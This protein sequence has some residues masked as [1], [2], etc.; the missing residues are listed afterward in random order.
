MRVTAWWRVRRARLFQLWGVGVV[1]SLAVTTA[2]ALGYFS[3][4]QSRALDFMQRLQ[5]QR[6]ASHIVV[7]A[8]DDDAFAALGS[9]TPIPREYVA[10]IVRGLQRSGAA[11]VGFDF[12]FSSPTT[13]AADGALADAI[14]GFNERGLSRVVLADTAA[15]GEGPLGDRRLL[16]SLVRGTPR[17]PVDADGII[18]RAML[19]VPRGPG[20]V[21]EPALS[22]AVAARLA[23]LDQSALA[24]AL[25]T[26]QLSLPR[27]DASG[28]SLTTAQPVRL[29]EGETLPIA[30]VGPAQ[31][32]LTI[33]SDAVAA[34]ADPSAEIADDNPLRGRVVLVGGT[35]K[36]ARDSFPT[37]VG[38]VP[39]VE[40]HAALV[41]M[42]LTRTFIRPTGWLTSLALQA[43]VVVLAG[44]VLTLARPLI[45][46]IV[47]LGTALLVGLPASYLA[48]R[49]AGYWVDFL[50]PVLATC[51]LGIGAD[52]LARRRVR[53][54]FGRYVSREVA[55][56]ILA[57]EPSLDGERRE[58]SILISDLRGFT[59]LSE[60]M[61]PVRI[62]RHLNEYFEAMTAAIFAHRGMVND[63][64]GDS[65]IAVFGAPLSDPDHARHATLS[66]IAMERALS[67]LNQRWQAAGLPTLRQGVGIHTGQV[68]AGNVGS[69][70]RVKYTVIGDPVNVAARLEG[71]NKELGTTVLMTEETHAIVKDRVDVK[72]RGTIAVKGRVQPVRVYEVLAV[73]GDG[74]APRRRDR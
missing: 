2:S 4:V 34:L 1:A 73:L 11:V 26:R 44:L 45:G 41:H 18:R 20:G 30:F 36:E 10:R 33:P 62:A 59:T 56:R 27:W 63:F 51:L 38:I 58:V 66:A 9:R 55:A 47:C 49:R 48:F 39:G 12:D 23:G 7:V 29:T 60:T 25:A 42:L 70:T 54:S 67:G 71:L 40:V 57:E 46:T 53:E 14:A 43:G 21:T 3:S 37:P 13:P 68:F 17:V 69:S 6:F 8:V 64:V 28:S 32:F 19:L 24:A 22:V 72:D 5:G 74:E 16:R 31:S 52:V 65:I 35:Y 15:E 61:E 50:L